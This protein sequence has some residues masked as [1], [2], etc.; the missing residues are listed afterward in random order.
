[1]IDASLRTEPETPFQAL[2]ENNGSTVK[3]DPEFG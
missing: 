3:A 1:M 2:E